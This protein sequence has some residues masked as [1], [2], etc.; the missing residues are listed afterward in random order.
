M[1]VYTNME[2]VKSGKHGMFESSRIRAT[3]CGHLYDVT[4]EED[5]D[6]G[7]LVLV[8]GYTGNG[9]QEREGAVATTKDMVAVTGNPALIK[10][11]FTTQQ[12]QPYNY[13]N[14]ANNPVKCYELVKEDIFAVADYQFT[15]DSKEHIKVGS[16]VIV[17][18]N[19]AYKAQVADPSAT[20]GFVGKIHSIYT[21]TYFTMVRIEVVQNTT[22]A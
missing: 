22:I 19:G 2:A 3:N 12:N 11:A 16:Y 18:G 10:D 14:R 8:K 1:A 20:N 7:V 9:L 21:T 6:N 15:E 13:Y 5:I 4:F 17:D